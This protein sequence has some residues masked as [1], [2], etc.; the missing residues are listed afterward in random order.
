MDGDFICVLGLF[1]NETI[2]ITFIHSLFIG[3]YLSF[4]IYFVHSPLSEGLNN[5]GKLQLYSLDYLTITLAS[6]LFFEIIIF[7]YLQVC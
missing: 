5:K 3:H 6:F 4:L 1:R 7:K 2:D